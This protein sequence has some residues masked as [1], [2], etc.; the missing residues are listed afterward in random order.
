[1]S[2]DD[3]GDDASNVDSVVVDAAKEAAAATWTSFST[4]KQTNS[5][6]IF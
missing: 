4:P 5:G 6:N 1:M 2:G 3:E